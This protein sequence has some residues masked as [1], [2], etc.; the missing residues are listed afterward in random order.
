MERNVIL[1]HLNEAFSRF[2]ELTKSNP[3][4]A[5]AASLYGLAVVTY[6]LK[7][8]PG[9]IW[10]K[11]KREL[12]TTLVINSSDTIYYDFLKWV[13]INKNHSFVRNFNY[14][15]LSRYG[16]GDSVVSIGYGR[17]Y[18]MLG[19]HFFAMDRNKVDANNTADKKE[20]ISL[21]LLGR[22]KKVLENLFEIIQNSS[23]TESKYT[24]LYHY[25]DKIWQV[26][27][28]CYKRNLDTVIVEKEIKNGL[29]KTIDSF[30]N[31][32]E[33]YLEKGVPWRLGI[34][35]SGPPGTGKTS[36]VKA[37]CSHYNKDLYIVNL[38][39]MSDNLLRDALSSVP[40]GAIVVIEDIDAGGVGVTRK[41][42][43]VGPG[44][45]PGAAPGAGEPEVMGVTLSG[46]L[47]AIDGVASGEGRI[48]IA[49]TNHIENL[50]WA[51][52]REGRFDFKAKIGYM[53][54]ETYREYL[55]R[56]YDVDF[57]E[58]NVK[59]NLAPCTLQKLVFDNRENPAKVLEETSLVESDSLMNRTI[60]ETNSHFSN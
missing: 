31:S 23:K 11:I 27:S 37:L 42:D 28:Q 21:T 39:S 60:Y 54:D 18:F 15:N 10:S 4:I 41:A 45:A 7:D 13:S 33:W 55:E 59:L 35:L 2:N 51:L 22:N 48:L 36:L 19:G 14:T 57:S 12:T 46:V 20:V 9:T 43:V 58:Y 40:E 6:V 56:F 25:R 3:V 32:K 38:I 24:K 5:G 30:I 53:T 29:L 16:Y 26:F 17:I 44:A 52:I 50:D 1:T 49:T 8:I 47:N 34:M